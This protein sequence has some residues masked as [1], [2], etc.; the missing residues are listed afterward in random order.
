M[1]CFAKSKI[2]KIGLMWNNHLGVPNH[3]L[4]DKIK[5]M[6]FKNLPTNNGFS[7]LPN[8]LMYFLKLFF[9]SLK[10]WNFL[11]KCLLSFKL[12]WLD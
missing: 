1:F 11:T 12:D 7:T 9:V 6:F 5:K 4:E 3:L 10:K 8:S 2:P